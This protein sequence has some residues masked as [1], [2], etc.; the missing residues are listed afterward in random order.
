M[1]DAAEPTT[2]PDRESAGVEFKTTLSDSRKIIETIAAM[3][4]MGGGTIWVGIRPDG[5]PVGCEIG[6]G[7][8]E[9]L[10][11]RILAA[12]DPKVH[13]KLDAPRYEGQRLLRIQVPAGD[14][15][16]LAYGRA[17]HRVG[18][19]TVAMTRDE[20]ERRLVDRLR[21]SSGFER[22]SEL[23]VTLDEVDP[24]AIEQFRERVSARGDEPPS[25]SRALLYKLHLVR[26][27]EL[28]VGGVLL[29]ALD[30]QRVLPQAVIRARATR[31]V[32]ED[33]EEIGGNLFDQILRATAFVSRNL[34]TR[35]IREGV[36]RQ[37]VPDLPV[38]AVREVV[39]NAVAHRD[40]RSTAPIQL[41]LDDEGLSVWSPG[42]L[43]PPIT[44][45]LLRQDHPSIPP[46][47][48]LAR[49]LHRAGF[50][51][52]WGTGTLLVIAALR[53]AGLPE[54]LFE[55][56]HGAGVRVQLPMAG[57]VAAHLSLRQTQFLDSSEVGSLFTTAEYASSLGVSHSTA[58]NDLRDIEAYGLIERQGQ[59]KSS[60]WIRR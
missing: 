17:F 23:G 5:T 26:G 16:H 13:V 9:R 46:N 57:Q 56:E 51:E 7:E 3:A 37:E 11:Q 20:Y 54:P 58:L 53:D 30:P 4:T 48:Y 25:D 10:V 18:P 40:Y 14:G 34:R 19:A 38:A 32:A 35:V 49:A 29:F 45:A 36:L 6:E 47:P 31:G 42:H 55:E 59:G 2:L 27:D 50:I 21:E 44:P 28:T 39:A 8:L 12:T 33:A 52:E 24:H 60:R 15:A 43:P 41:R 22:R 1:A